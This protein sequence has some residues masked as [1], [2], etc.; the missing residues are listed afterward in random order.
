MEYSNK[1]SA[2]ILREREPKLQGGP[3]GW[4]VLLARQTRVREILA[5]LTYEVGLEYAHHFA[6]TMASKYN[7]KLT[8]EFATRDHPISINVHTPTIEYASPVE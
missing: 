2:I 4:L 8:E 7:V 6:H 1:V 3:T 5:V